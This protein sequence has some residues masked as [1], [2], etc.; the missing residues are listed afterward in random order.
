MNMI[1]YEKPRMTFV[2]LRNESKVADTCWGNHGKGVVY[3]CDIPSVGYMSFEIEEGN[4]AL[5]LINVTY[6][7]DHDSAGVF[8]D[9]GDDRYKQLMSRLQSSGGGTDANPYKGLGSV[10]VPDAPVETWS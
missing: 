9:S 2:S 1:T 3:Y 4:C 6:Y 10:V 7:E 8:V 5:N